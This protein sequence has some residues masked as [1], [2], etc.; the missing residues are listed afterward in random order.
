MRPAVLP[1]FRP[2][3]TESLRARLGGVLTAVTL[4][5]GALVLLAAAGFMLLRSDAEGTDVVQREGP[6][7]FNFRYTDGLERIAPQGDELVHLEA[8]RSDLFVQSFAVSPLR[9]PPYRGEVVG[10][11]PLFAAREIDALRDRFAEFELVQDGK[12]RVNEAPGYSVLF[13][14]R[15]GRR[16]LY[17]RYIMLPAPGPG[18]RDGV[19]LALLATPAAGVSKAA[20]VGVRGVIKR[21]YRTF[22][23]GAERP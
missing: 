7:Q 1:E 17:G 9:L 10:Y 22:R 20:D 3:L 2:T 4:G 11:L 18:S 12:T 23:F 8:R 19:R 15:L 6:V 14:A 13:R 21:P 5:I 16:R